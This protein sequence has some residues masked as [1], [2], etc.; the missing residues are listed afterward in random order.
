MLSYFISAKMMLHNITPNWSNKNIKAITNAAVTSVF[1][2]E[3]TSCYI[4]VL[5][6][7]QVGKLISGTSAYLGSIKMNL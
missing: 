2:I 1:A 3:I 4:S 7:K 5:L 6:G